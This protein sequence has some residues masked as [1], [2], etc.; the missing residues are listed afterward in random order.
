MGEL[1]DIQ[2]GHRLYLSV[3]ILD[4]AFRVAFTNA[5]AHTGIPPQNPL[6]HPGAA[7]PLRYYY[8][9][10]AVCAVC[11]KLAHVSARQAL[12]A[13]SVWAGIGLVALMA[14]FARHFLG[15]RERLNRFI[16]VAALLLTV[17]GLDILPALHELFVS[18]DFGG[19]LEWWST[20]QIASWLDTILWVP[21]HT[22]AL[23]CCLMALLL[24]WRTREQLARKQ[25]VI[26]TILAGVAAASAFGLSVYVAAGFAMLMVGWAASLFFRERNV[27]LVRRMA[28]AVATAA[29]LLLPYLR[30]LA[31]SRSGTQERAA[32]GPSHLFQLSVRKMIDSELITRLDVF[33]KLNHAHPVLLDQAVR[34]VL[35]LPGYALELGVYA[36]VLVLALLDRKRLNLPDRTALALILGGFFLVSFLR[37]SVIGNNDFGYR[38]ALLPCFLLLLLTAEKL[39]SI[40]TSMQSQLLSLLIFAGV[41]GTALQ[42]LMLRSYVPLHVAAHMQGFEGL[43]EAA[44]DARTAYTAA[45][46]RIPPS[47]IVQAN[48]VATARYFSMVNML[49]S[50]RAM[51]TDAEVDCGAVFGGDPASC[52]QTQKT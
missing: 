14:L 24:L 15:V 25:A 23:L 44:F 16:L 27:A 38:A 47:A 8:F 35:L 36:L 9:W 33:A 49:Y 17:T 40:R 50:E 42:A 48:P 30:D 6:Y 51:V 11:M 52:L 29:I 45:A 43:P 21:N 39:T 10:Y 46:A 18:H 41:A 26:A 20:D 22:A 7:A 13:S 34:L 1:V 12:I 32:A 2:R 5:I 31:G 28:M 3:T 19:D 4:Q 37:S